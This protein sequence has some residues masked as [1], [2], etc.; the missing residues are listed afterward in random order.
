MQVPFWLPPD[1][2]TQ[3]LEWEAHAFVEDFAAELR[4]AGLGQLAQRE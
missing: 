3:R 1:P 2:L 4:V